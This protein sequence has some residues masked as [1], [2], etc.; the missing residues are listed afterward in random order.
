[1]IFFTK[2]ATLTRRSTVLSLPLQL[3]LRAGNTETD[4]PNIKQNWKKFDIFYYHWLSYEKFSF[5]TKIFLL[6]ERKY[7]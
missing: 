6:F 3:E 7:S 4:H 5:E 2:Q 1:M